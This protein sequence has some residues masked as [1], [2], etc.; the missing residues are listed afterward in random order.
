MLA[1]STRVIFQP[2]SHDIVDITFHQ[3][4]MR[5]SENV[6]IASASAS[7]LLSITYVVHVSA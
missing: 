3:G 6:F 2:Q 5:V 4:H 7:L 1:L